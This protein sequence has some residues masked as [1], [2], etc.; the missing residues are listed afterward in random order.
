MRR[1]LAVLGLL[2][3]AG[4]FAG[5]G[6]SFKLPTENRDLLI[7]SDKSYQ[8]VATWTG[9][10]GIRDILL[11][12]GMGTQLFLLFNHGGMGTAPRGEVLAYARLKP[13]GPQAPLPGIAFQGLFNP[14]ALCAG[15]DGGS[16]ASNRIF[17]LDQGDT[18]LARVNP[19]TH[20]YGDTTGLF[21]PDTSLV[22]K[23]RLYN[24]S[25]PELYWRVREYGLLGGDTI[26]TFTDT[27]MAFVQGI[28]ADAQGRVYV[29]GPLLAFVPD[30][31]VPNKYERNFLW[32][33]NRYV[34]GPISPGV[35][36]GYMPGSNWHKDASF[37]VVDGS[38]TGTVQDPRSLYWGSAGPALYVADFGKNWIQR[39]MDEVP[40]S[41]LKIEQAEGLSL[42]GPLDVTAD[43]QGFIYLADTGNQRVLRFDG[44]GE[45]VQTVNVENDAYG[46][47]LMNPVTVAADDSLVFVGDS[48]LSQVVRY[49]RRP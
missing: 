12:Q 7:P 4:G 8:M 16:S 18:L 37:V 1:A 34:R 24:V 21:A 47:Q 48:G 26:S 41:D 32:R 15:G 42:Y 38:G 2:V 45:Y 49:K 27:S 46:Q 6:G 29:S 43:L 9:M 14:A 19:K 31:L 33:V 23:W 11:T 20:V 39:M 40:V 25:H 10:E 5:C 36:D 13:S 22:G 17:V 28:A 35:Y 44:S 30:V 3:V